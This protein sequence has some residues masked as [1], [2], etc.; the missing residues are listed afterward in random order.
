MMGYSPHKTQIQRV[1]K[2]FVELFRTLD[3]TNSTHLKVALL[4]NYFHSAHAEDKIWALA[5]F[6]GR[7]PK[8][9]IAT[10]QL[11]EWAAETA[12]LPAW[13][14][15]EC[16]HNVGDLGETIA[17]LVENKNHTSLLSLSQWFHII[18]D[19][20]GK[21]ESEKKAVILQAWH[22]LDKYEI[23]VFNKL[24]MGSLRVGVSQTLVVRALSE[25]TGIST[26]VITHR[27]MGNWD[28][29]KLSFE[30]LIFSGQEGEISTPYPF[31]LAQPIEDN[32][33]GLS[34]VNDWFVEWKWDGIR[35]QV[36]K[37]KGELFIWS[38]GEELVTNKFPEL[39]FLKEALGD[40]TVL[41]G[42][43]VCLD[44]S[45]SEIQTL[46]FGWLQKR[47]SRKNVTKNVMESSPA[48]I[49]LYDVLE[50][51]GEDIR[52]KI[53]S[54]RRKILENIFY[55]LSHKTVRLS[56]LVVST[57]WEQ[58][59]TIQLKAREV[60]AEGLMIKRKNA[61]YQSGRKKGDWWKWKV[62]PMTADAVLVYAQKGH[63]KRAELFTD[64]TFAVWEQGKLL[65]F[66][67]AYSGLTDKEITEIDR[68]IK[69][70]TLEKFGPV[71]TVKPELVF[72]IG[73][74]GMQHS[75]R[76]KSGIAVRFPRILRW[77]KDKNAEDADTVTQLKKMLDETSRSS[78]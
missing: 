58:L 12:D 2:L 72:E 65:P 76:H 33:K 13:L 46:P 47:I 53:H 37:R 4:K 78:S 35:A 9:N 62:D 1:M 49:I 10:S 3:S 8:R 69:A 15:E 45:A 25:L 42:E 75:S 38:R 54:E 66:A 31:F 19:L 71:R 23:L 60:K 21:T 73:F 55:G 51:K 11:R 59:K 50:F 16:Y 26:A 74:E 63:G 30:Q 32:G 56:P 27:L 57:S 17:L 61:A 41:D 34:E 44:T 48:G 77:R 5:L 28:P 40:G 24:L 68:F 20:N 39:H 6:S 14:F 67:K 18:I 43:L 52:S 70:N 64:Y 36:I 29:A 22:T 7:R